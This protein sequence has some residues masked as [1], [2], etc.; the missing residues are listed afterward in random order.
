M[1]SPQL[2]EAE[3]GRNGVRSVRIYKF[4]VDVDT[5]RPSGLGI[6]ALLLVTQWVLFG[7]V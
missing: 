2:F 1:F 4:Q 5:F 3:F 7:L 6:D